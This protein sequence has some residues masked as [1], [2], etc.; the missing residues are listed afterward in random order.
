[1]RITPAQAGLRAVG[2]R[3][4]VTGLRR[5]EVAMLAGISVEYYTQLE[6]GTVRGVSEDVLDSIARALQLD[7][8]ERTHLFDL[9]RSAKQRPTKG[10]KVA[11]HVRPG[12]QRLLD[13]M[14]E[15]AAFVRNSRLDILSAN[16]LGYALY[17]EAFSN[18]DRPANLARFV[19]LDPRARDFYVDWDGIADA[20]AG[21]L[22][23]AAG[24]DPYDRDLTDLVG[25][26]SMRSEDFRE[27]WAAHDVRQY[28]TGTQLF[29]HAL[30][31]DLSLTYEALEVTA[32][33]DQILVGYTAAP[34]SSSQ[35]ALR[36][37]ANWAGE[38]A[39]QVESGRNDPG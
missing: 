11:E 28:R 10:R 38:Q 18:P 6:R 5:E 12:V 4:R 15:A 35:E 36:R 13:S 1:A 27:R 19:F 31:G 34:G 7:D 9:V 37:L 33:V 22:R 39:P 8:V 25:E 16:R 24:R 23:A 26:L 2:S 30:V 32:E 17:S 29:R 21:S 20:G 3:R 14:T